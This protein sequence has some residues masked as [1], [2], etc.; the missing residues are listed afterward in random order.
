MARKRSWYSPHGRSDFTQEAGNA[1]ELFLSHVLQDCMRKGPGEI[2]T[3]EETYEVVSRYFKW[4]E[5]GGHRV[6]PES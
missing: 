6:L 3:L 2:G 4:N 1:L 5:G